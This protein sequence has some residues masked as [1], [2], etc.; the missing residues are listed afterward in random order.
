MPG[1]FY[2]RKKE[3][4]MKRFVVCLLPLA[5]LAGM[6]LRAD[7][8]LSGTYAGTAVHNNAPL[9]YRLT[10]KGASACSIRAAA[11]V[12]GREMSQEAEGT[13]SLGGDFFR[14]NAVFPDPLIPAL[15]RLQLVSVI[16]FNGDNSFAILVTPA[17]GIPARVVFIKEDFSFSDKSLSENK[18][19][20]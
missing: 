15:T 2:K 10:F 3:F 11:F 14:L 18:Y 5:L 6:P 7:P 19:Y 12:N 16:S 9:A 1:A 13:W 4:A 8:A 17:G 20:T